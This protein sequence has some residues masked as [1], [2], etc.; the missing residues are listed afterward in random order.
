[1]AHESY[2]DNDVSLNDLLDD[3][4]SISGEETSHQQYVAPNNTTTGNP[5]PTVPPMVNLN[6][7]PNPE[8]PEGSLLHPNVENLRSY[9][10]K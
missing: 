3:V 8:D 7:I 10:R 2:S 9:L 4:T 6:N 1:M 5:T